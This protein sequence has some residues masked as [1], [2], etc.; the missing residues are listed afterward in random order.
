MVVRLGPVLLAQF[1]PLVPCG[2][3]AIVFFVLPS[4]RCL[5]G[6]GWRSGR[7]GRVIAKCGTAACLS[8]YVVSAT[9]SRFSPAAPRVCMLGPKGKIDDPDEERQVSGLAGARRIQEIEV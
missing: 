7:R 2:G 4:N 5:S 6:A 3:D 8:M 1:V 9:L